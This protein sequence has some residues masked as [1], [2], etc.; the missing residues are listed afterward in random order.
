MIS[1]FRLKSSV[2]FSFFKVS[3]LSWIERK[4]FIGITVYEIKEIIYEI[5]SIA[6]GCQYAFYK[7]ANWIR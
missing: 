3:T 6:E 2:F 7:N 1:E 5:C 4:V